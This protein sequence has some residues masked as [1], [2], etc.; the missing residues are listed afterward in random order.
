MARI[1]STATAVPP[2]RLPR[3]LYRQY[4]EAKFQGKERA[5]RRIIDHTRIDMRYLSKS[6]DELLRERSLDEKSAD[7][8]AQALAL[9]EETAARALDRAGV[10]RQEVDLIVTTSCT[11]VMIPSVDA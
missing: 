10:R 8:S 2:H 7:Y 9:C 5:A 1:L 4:C 11:G 6:P 3:E